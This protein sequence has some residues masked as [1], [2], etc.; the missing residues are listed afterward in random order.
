M[1]KTFSH[2]RMIINT[3]NDD[4]PFL[5]LPLKGGLERA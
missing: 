3:K 4:L 5:S 1:N 2:R